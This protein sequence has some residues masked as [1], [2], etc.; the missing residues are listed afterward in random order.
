MKQLLIVLAIAWPLVGVAQSASKP[1]GG[2]DE[3]GPVGRYMAISE[4]TGA[5]K[6]PLKTAILLDT[7]T[8]KS[9]LLRAGHGPGG[10]PT[11]SWVPIGFPADTKLPE[12]TRE[13]PR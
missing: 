11:F 12:G 9:W 13:F 1:S 8:G 7:V 5:T 4:I 3:K 6:S 10:V 2:P